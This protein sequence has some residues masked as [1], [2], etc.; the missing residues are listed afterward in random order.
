MRRTQQ[1]LLI[2][3]LFISLII[4]SF[5]QTALAHVTVSPKE[6]L[7]AS[8]QTFTVNVPNEKDLA[9]IQIKLL[10]PDGLQH[11]LPTQKYGWHIDVDKNSNDQTSLAKSITW[12]GSSIAVGLRDEFTFSAKTPDSPTQIQWKAYQTYSDGTIV[13]WDQD[14]QDSTTDNSGPASVTTITNKTAQQTIDSGLV[15]PINNSQVTNERAVYLGIA[16]V[17]LGLIAIF[18]STRKNKLQ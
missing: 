5:K 4:L 2:F 7:T 6:A 8:F 17:S 3:S 16:G 18:L 9:T 1:S 11:V 15:Q 14:S 12:S 10:L 13:A